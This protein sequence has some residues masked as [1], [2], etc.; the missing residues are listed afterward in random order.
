MPKEHE[1]A[2]DKPLTWENDGY[3]GVCPQCR[4]NDGYI[5]AGRSHWFFCKEHRVKWWV[6]ANLFSSWRD[7]TE[8]EQPRVY[9]EIGLGEFEE[10]KPLDVPEPQHAACWRAK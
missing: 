8:A 3:W 5:N 10:I 2:S 4:R 6:G 1:T 7:E 9:D